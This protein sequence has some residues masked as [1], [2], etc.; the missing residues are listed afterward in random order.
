[1][2]WR[3]SQQHGNYCALLLAVITWTLPVQGRSENGKLDLTTLEHDKIVGHFNGA[4][5]RGIQFLSEIKDGYQVLQ[6]TTLQ[7]E[8]LYRTEGHAS[9]HVLA[10][11]LGQELLI[12][13]ITGTPSQ[14]SHS[15]SYHVPSNWSQLT[16]NVVRQKMSLHTVLPYLDQEKANS[17]LRTAISALLPRLETRY[18]VMAAR[19]LGKD[20]RILGKEYPAA[21]NLYVLAM[22]LSKSPN[23]VNAEALAQSSNYYD[24]S[25]AFYDKLHYR[26]AIEKAAEHSML[27]AIAVVKTNPDYHTKGELMHTTQLSLIWQEAKST[28]THLYWHMKNCSG[29]PDVL[30]A[31][32]MRI[33]KHF[34]IPGKFLPA[35]VVVRAMDVLGVELAATTT[36]GTSW[37]KDV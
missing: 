21:M 2:V 7:G 26:N 5:N 11:I 32:M 17:T 37:L 19:A 3:L 36:G 16:K 29:D 24:G 34:Q 1:M 9:S 14:K 27:Q 12:A 6:I 20:V 18:V 23:R 31:R 4:K 33:S 13:N 30:G 15:S 8:L 28:K 35:T 25:N 10:S 22:R